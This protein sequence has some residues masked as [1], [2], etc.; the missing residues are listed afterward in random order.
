MINIEHGPFW[1]TDGAE[2]V[3]SFPTLEEALHQADAISQAMQ[4]CG[5]SEEESEVLIAKVE[6]VNKVIHMGP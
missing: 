4:E 1:I 2:L 6:V 3:A 5:M